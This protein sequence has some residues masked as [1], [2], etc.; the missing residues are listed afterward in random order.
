MK[1]LV[2][3]VQELVF[4]AA[5][6]KMETALFTDTL[7]EWLKLLG[8]FGS[9]IEFALSDI[10]KKASIID[11]NNRLLLELAEEKDHHRLL[12][13]EDTIAFEFEHNLAMLNGNNF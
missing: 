1:N 9:V 3:K 12:T 8:Y 10:S 5:Q 6:N 7:R 13:I 11:D 2:P 4:Q